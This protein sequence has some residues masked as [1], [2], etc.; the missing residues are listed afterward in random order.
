[1]SWLPGKCHLTRT[2]LWV[3]KGQDH[4]KGLHV[5]QSHGRN[6]MGAVPVSHTPPGFL[7]M[8]SLKLLVNPNR[9][10]IPDSR[11][12]C[13]V[14]SG[15]LLTLRVILHCRCLGLSYKMG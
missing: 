12:S 6:S 11:V 9:G 8:A 4:M 3:G 1:M 7:L 13:A 5:S 15:G 10:R 14:Q 2:A